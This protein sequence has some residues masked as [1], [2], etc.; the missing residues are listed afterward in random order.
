[1]RCGEARRWHESRWQA[2]HTPD[3]RC[4][5]WRWFGWRRGK[6]RYT[7][8]TWFGP[9]ATETCRA[10]TPVC[11]MDGWNASKPTQIM[12]QRSA[13]KPNAHT[14]TLT[15]TQP[16]RRYNILCSTNGPT[17]PERSLRART[18][19]D[20]CGQTCRGG[21]GREQGMGAVPGGQAVQVDDSP[22]GYTSA[23]ITDTKSGA[24]R[25]R[26][27]AAA[28]EVRPAASA[29]RHITART[30]SARRAARRIEP[31]IARVTH[32][33]THTTLTPHT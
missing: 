10:D 19:R 29:Y 15:H 1:M 30:R 7:A 9:K 27:A 8:S 4:R 17:G 21:R 31:G 11:W 12:P 33:I 16:Q 32:Q 23:H 28:G 13:S 5:R 20:R 24:A 22:A 14:N 3:R 25:A 6:G 18:V 2:A 26:A